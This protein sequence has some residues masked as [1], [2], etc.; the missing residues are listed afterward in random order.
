MTSILRRLWYRVTRRRRDADLAEEMETH[1]RL[2]QA[3]LERQGASPADAALASRRAFGNVTLAREDAHDVWTWAWIEHAGQDLRIALRG[4]RQSPTFTLVAVCTLALGIGANT[5]LFSIV[6][7]LLLRQLPVRD[8]AGLVL[9]DQGSWTYPIFEAVE[10]Q[11]G[12]AF[13]G[14]FAYANREFD[15]ASGG[16]RAPIDGAYASGRL[17]DVLGVTAARGRLLSPSDDRR[18]GEPTVAVISYRFWQQRYGGADSVLGSTLSLDR[19]AFTIVGVM[20]ATFTGPDVGRV[21]DVMVPFAA[22]PVLLGAESALPRRTTWWLDIMARL[23]PGTSLAQANAGL[24]ALQPGIREAAKPERETE[25]LEEPL[26]LVPAA[27]GRSP[28]R[29]RFE[30]PLLAMLATVGVVLLIACANL[31]NLMLARALARRRELSLRLALGATRWRVARLLAFETVA[32]VTAGAAIGVM[33]AKWSSA[34]LVRQLATWRGTITLD[35]SLDWR[36]LA[37]TTALACLTAVIAGILPAFAVTG[38][39]PGDAMK[40]SGRTIA[41]D[42][43]LSIRG[44]LVVSQIALSLV[45]V[46]GAGLFL[47]TFT[48][49]SQVPLGFAPGGLTVA[50]VSLAASAGDETA[51]PDLVRRLEAAVA[52]SPGVRATGLS[53]VAPISGSGWNDSIGAVT[54]GRASPAT[55]TWINAVTPAWFETMG[56]RLRSGRGFEAT[57]RVGGPKV[58]IVNETFARRFLAGRPPVGQRVIAGGPRD[59]SDYEVVG[60]VGDAVYRS[61]REGMVP[62]MYLPLTQQERLGG[63]ITLTVAT[64]AAARGSADR[65][66]ADALRGVDPAL[67]FTLRD[68]DQFLRGGLTQERLVALLSTFFGGLALLLAAVGLY[69]VVTHAVNVRRTEIGVRMALGASR[70]GILWLVFRRVG[71]M[72]ALGLAAG[73]ALSLWTSRFVGALLFRLEPRDATTFAGAVAVLVVVSLL[74]AWIPARRAARVDPALVLRD[75]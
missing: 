41:G 64:T 46:I 27:T 21:A 34:L 24:R 12:P 28:L 10:A 71:V 2:R 42:R 25:F 73:L 55:M 1:R 63:S 75:S 72:L 31:A 58:A 50:S 68:F 43:R 7:S 14:V 8:P 56:I 51:R 45:L 70:A 65:I 53:V 11:A 44:A 52:A 16:Q 23:K 17:F 74:A 37:F 20:P 36:V 30:T 15:L 48:A 35:L 9:L 57:D 5:A 13:D 19:Q 4:L 6:N 47:R 39:A 33:F 69:G 3:Q 40:E 61:L 60:V 59:R 18:E 26:T 62:T 32:I 66:V 38:V 29:R 54:E 22:E 67:T 49:L